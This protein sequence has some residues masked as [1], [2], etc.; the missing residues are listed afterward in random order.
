MVADGG[1]GAMMFL[2]D[3]CGREAHH[4]FL[5]LGTQF[6]SDLCGREDLSDIKGADSQISKRPMRS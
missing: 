3:L 1:I 6:L 2:S 5:L 4:H